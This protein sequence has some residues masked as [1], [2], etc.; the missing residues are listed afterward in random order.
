MKL[1]SE[2]S[3]IRNSNAHITLSVFRSVFMKVV[4]GPQSFLSRP[5]EKPQD[6]F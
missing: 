4:L 6:R 5:M 1:A 2:I 3:G